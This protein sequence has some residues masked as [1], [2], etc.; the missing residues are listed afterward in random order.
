MPLYS[1]KCSATGA[2]FDRFESMKE[3]GRETVCQCG[4]AA[5]K[6]YQTPPMGFVESDCTPH[7]APRTGE[8]INSNHKRREFMKRN[9]LMDANDFTP[10][11]IFREQKKRRDAL[12]REAAK[13]YEDL[14]SGMKPEKVLNEVLSK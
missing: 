9:G 1:Y 4:A 8:I 10:D 12:K 2:V 14:P 7:K 6:F 11:Y 3:T 5:P 13:A